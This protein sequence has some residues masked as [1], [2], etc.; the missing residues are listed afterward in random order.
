MQGDSEP[1][2]GLLPKA[3]R[4]EE[5]RVQAPLRTPAREEHLRCRRLESRPPERAARESRQEPQKQ[6]LTPF[7]RLPEALVPT[8]GVAKAVLSLHPQHP[9]ASYAM[10]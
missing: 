6:H 2:V 3:Q 7:P 8:A 1:Q 5:C 4:P 10:V 9:V